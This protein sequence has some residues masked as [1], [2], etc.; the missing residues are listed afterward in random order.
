MGVLRM[1]EIDKMPMNLRIASWQ[2]LMMVCH[3]LKLCQQILN[4]WMSGD[5]IY[6]QHV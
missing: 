3:E 1:R 5:A 4:L 2:S 6:V